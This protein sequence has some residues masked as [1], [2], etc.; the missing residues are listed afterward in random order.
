MKSAREKAAKILALESIL[1]SMD[2]IKDVLCKCN[3]EEDEKEAN[4]ILKLAEAFEKV[5]KA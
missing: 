1:M 5:Y 2:A 3:V 4:A